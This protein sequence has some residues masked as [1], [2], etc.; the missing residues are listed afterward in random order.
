M[1]RWALLVPIAILLGPAAA[2][3]QLPSPGVSPPGANDPSCRPTKGHTRPIV[4]VHG[5]GGDMS[6]SW[7][8]ISPEL[9]ERGYCVYALDY[10]DRGRGPIEDSARE[11]SDFVDVVLKQTDAN[12]VAIVG[13][14]QGGMMPRYYMK[15]LGGKKKVAELIGLVPSNHGT[16]NPFAPLVP[17]CTACRQQVAGSPF[18]QKVNSGDETPGRRTSF[19]QITTEFDQVV[20]PYTSAFLTGRK[21]TNVVLQDKC[22]G[23]QTEHLGIIYDPVALQLVKDALRRQGRPANPDFQP[24]C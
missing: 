17:G 21:T 10:G 3:A 6:V 19:T 13:H 16:T 11:L 8:L 12:K 2:S 1:R 23:N 4:L 5:T 20:L 24:E 22:P 15:Y 18:M 7:N 14:S 9:A